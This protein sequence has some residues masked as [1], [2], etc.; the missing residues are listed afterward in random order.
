[1]S[2]I[3]LNHKD[4]LLKLSIDKQ[5]QYLQLTLKKTKRRCQFFKN[6][7][8]QKECFEVQAKRA[9]KSVNTAHTY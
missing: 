4:F 5:V 7:F 9:F 8:T 1:M 6:K 2:V 3:K